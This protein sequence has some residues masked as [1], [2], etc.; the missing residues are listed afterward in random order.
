M[1]IGEEQRS[2]EMSA[3]GGGRERPS[4]WVEQPKRKSGAGMNLVCWW[5]R[6]RIWVM[7]QCAELEAVGCDARW[8]IRSRLVSIFVIIYGQQHL[9]L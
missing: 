1:R 8:E 7:V 4:R 2:G 9:H 5:W 6:S 3:I